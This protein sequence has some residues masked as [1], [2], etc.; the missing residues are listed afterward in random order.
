MF[1]YTVSQG[2]FPN[3]VNSD[4]LMLCEFKNSFYYLVK[5][6]EEGGIAVAQWLRFCAT[7]R[8]VA[9]SNPDGVIGF[10]R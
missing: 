5:L 10:F 8:K 4:P 9:G 1:K 6:C 2:E 3:M 7:N